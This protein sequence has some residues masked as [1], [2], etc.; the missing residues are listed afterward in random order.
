MSCVFER[1]GAVWLSE[2]L[3]P[4]DYR[5]SVAAASC[6]HTR[7]YLNYVVVGYVAF[8]VVGLAYQEIHFSITIIAVSLNAFL[9]KLRGENLR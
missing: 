6:D 2:S 8:A 1:K 9:H 7:P 5:K 4:Y 3:Y